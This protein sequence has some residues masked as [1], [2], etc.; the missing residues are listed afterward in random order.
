MRRVHLT[1]SGRV[2]GVFFRASTRDEAR[3]LGL[4]GWAAN[5]PSGTVEIGIQGDDDDVDAF[6]AFCRLGPGQSDVDD[7]LVET[8]TVVSDEKTFD[9][10]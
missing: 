2:Q 6:I 4:T 10:R 7:L 5:M 3:R 1:A 9:V 8:A